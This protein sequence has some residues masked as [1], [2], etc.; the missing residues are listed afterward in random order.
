[1]SGALTALYGSYSDLLA[2]INCFSFWYV[3]SCFFL[4]KHVFLQNCSAKLHVEHQ[5]EGETEY[6]GHMTKM[7][8]TLVYKFGPLCV[9]E[10]NRFN[11]ENKSLQELTRVT[12][13]LNAFKN[14]NPRGLSAPVPSLYSSYLPIISHRLF[15]S[16][17]S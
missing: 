5:W 16:K 13:V 14:L 6:L 1:M 9:L 15:F 10:L 3:C 8:T 7:A 12:K 17:T 11:E 4:S 2:S